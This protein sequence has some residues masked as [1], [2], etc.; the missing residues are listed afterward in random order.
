MDFIK[1]VEEHGEEYGFKVVPLSDNP[2][3]REK[4]IEEERQMID[5][6]F[7]YVFGAGWTLK[8]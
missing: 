7:A 3:E 8:K 6:A 5:D 1:W 4:Q 2:D